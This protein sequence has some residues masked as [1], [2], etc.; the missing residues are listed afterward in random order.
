MQ[1]LIFQTESSY[2]VYI[3]ERITEELCSCLP[4]SY[5]RLALISDSNV[6]PL[7]GE[8]IKSLLEK[9]GATVFSYSIPAGESSKTHRTLQDI[10]A[11]LCECGITRTD[12][13]VAL[14]GGVVGDVVGFAAATYLRGVDYVQIPTSLL[15]MIDSSVGGKT[16]VNLPQGKNLVGAF[17]QPVAVM[18]D[19]TFLATL[20]KAEYRNGMGE[21]IKYACIADE[22]MFD[23]LR[24]GNLTVEEMLWRSLS[25]KKYAVEADT[26]DTGVRQMLNFGHTLGH[27]IE[28]LSGYSVAHGE[29]VGVGMVEISRYGEEQGITPVGTAQAISDLLSQYGLPVSV[30]YMREQL[31]AAAMSDKKRKGDM[32]TLVMLKQIG[33]YALVDKRIEEL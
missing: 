26:K 8:R 5:K 15:A 31:F 20:P 6:Y 28:T 3:G 22:K 12:A 2:P 14:G 17:H 27:A 1:K 4:K 10:Y 18:V 23:A 11:F 32:L 19:P 25:I 13:L 33:S 21:V 7:H 16:A 24:G 29:A 9:T 30:Q